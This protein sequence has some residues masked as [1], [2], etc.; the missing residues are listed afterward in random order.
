MSFADE[1]TAVVP[2]FEYGRFL[3]E[4]VESL[5]TQEGGPPR[6]VVVDDGSRGAE[7][8]EALAEVET[9]DHV[10]VLRQENAGVSAARNR[11]W[12]HTDTPYVLFLDADDRLAQSALVNLF[13]ELKLARESDSC[14]GFT[15]GWAR[16]FGDID[17]TW[18]LPAYDPLV[19]L[20]RHLI[21]A[22][23]LLTR[24]MLDTTGGYDGSLSTLE[25]WAFY[26]TALSHGIVGTR[27]ERIV[28]EYR[29][30]GG[31]KHGDDRRRYRSVRRH[32]HERHRALYA[33][34]RAL[35]ARSRLTWTGR[36]VHRWYW[37][38]R[39]IPARLERALYRL[40]LRD[41]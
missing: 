27:I 15:Y 33:S 21:G 35:A 31:G 38:P 32:L 13:G 2:C 19:L 8:L 18:R 4:A 9:W 11:G 34:R 24:D 7:T 30:H 28:V 22:T 39:P 41:R 29:Q 6:V 36:F 16:F 14:V 12:R 20:D 26:V 37:G 1:V 25:D 5:L 17:W 10:E 3:R 23:A 40:I